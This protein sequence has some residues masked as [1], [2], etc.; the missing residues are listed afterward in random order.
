MSKLHIER[1]GGMAGFGTAGS[2]VRSR[3]EVDMASLS[4]VERGAVDAL[5]DNSAGK[6]PASQVRDGF[7]YRITRT[8]SGKTEVVEAPEAVVPPVLSRSVKDELI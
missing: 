6:P 7:R 3:G 5:F 2:H 1:I 8:T 4:P